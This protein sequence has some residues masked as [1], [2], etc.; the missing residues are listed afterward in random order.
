MRDVRSKFF[1]IDQSLS[2]HDTQL[3]DLRSS[4][5]TKSFG[6]Y[7]MSTSSSTDSFSMDIAR[8]LRE[9]WSNDFSK[10]KGTLYQ[11]IDRIRAEVN[12]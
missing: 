1:K 3:R 2:E 8:N 12:S 9:E 10:F 6:G 5:D 7:S 11:E 4:R